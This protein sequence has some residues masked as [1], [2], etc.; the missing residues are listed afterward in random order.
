M[1]NIVSYIVCII[2][3]GFAATLGD[4]SLG[5][6]TKQW[7]IRINPAGYA[8]GIWGLI[9]SLILVFVIYQALPAKMVPMRN[10][11][12]IFD[13]IGYS[14]AV[15]MILNGAWLCIFTQNTPIFFFIG[16]VEIFCLL[17]SCLYIMVQS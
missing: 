7:A 10:D 12:V 8:F 4:A 16:A 1:V 5:D 14:F 3:N 13:C 15:N 6:I 2:L 17:S 11:K 9:Y